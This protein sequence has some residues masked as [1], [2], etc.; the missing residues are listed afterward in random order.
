MLAAIL[1][2]DGAQTALAMQIQLECIELIVAFVL[3]CRRTW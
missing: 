1:L 2:G 3:A